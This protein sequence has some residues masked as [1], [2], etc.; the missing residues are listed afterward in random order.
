LA[1]RAGLAASAVDVDVA[2]NGRLPQLDVA[3][4]GGPLGAQPQASG[5]FGQLGRFAGY[6]VGASLVFQAPIPNRA[7]RGTFAA[8]RA[9]AARAAA[10]E[11]AVRQQV[12]ADAVRLVASAERAARR[13]AVLTPSL[14]SAERDLEAERARFAAGRSTNFDVLRRQDEVAQVELRQLRARVDF[15]AARAGIDALT[16]AILDRMQ[17]TVR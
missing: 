7:A 4:N 12:E 9:G 15:E 11:T 8:A 17:V 2:R 5:A 14:P 1:A 10:N 3:A 13:L 16:G 6:T